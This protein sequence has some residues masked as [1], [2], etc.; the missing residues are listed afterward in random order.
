MSGTGETSRST[1]LRAVACVLLLVSCGGG[2]QG[3][4]YEPSRLS[5]RKEAFPETP[6]AVASG[7]RTYRRHCAMCHGDQGE[8]DGGS[9]PYLEPRPRDFT[10]GLFKFRSTASGELPTDEDLFRVIS[11]GA[12][13]TAMP[14]WGEGVFRLTE[15]QRWE[16]AYYV[17]SLGGEDFE[18][19]DF[20]PYREGVI[21]PYPPPPRGGP[22]LALAGRE[23]FTDEKKGGCVKCHGP[24]GRGNGPE[25]GAQRDDWGDAILPA[26]LTKSWRYKNG[27]DVRQIF[28]TLS[29]G[30]GGTPMPGYGE[31]LSEAERWS[32]AFF[33]RSLVIEPDASGRQVLVVKRAA[34]AIP[35]DPSDERWL[36]QR[37]LDVSMAGQVVYRPR[38]H[39]AAVDLVQVRAM[40][41]E[42]EI[43]FH[44]TWNDRTRDVEHLGTEGGEPPFSRHSTGVPSVAGIDDAF[45]PAK[46][47][48]ERRKGQFRDSLQ[49]QFPVTPKAGASKPFFFLGGAGGAVNLWRWFA[50]REA[51]GQER[52]FEEREQNGALKTPTVQEDGDQALRGSSAYDDGR[53]MLVLRRP[54]RTQG[55]KD[56]QFSAGSLVPFAVQA[57]D[58]GNGEEGL[59][60]SLSSWYYVRLEAPIPVS[61]YLAGVA[62]MVLASLL[63]RLFVF[64]ARRVAPEYLLEQSRPAGYAGEAA[65]AEEG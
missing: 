55:K 25:A 62:G 10:M 13:G 47:L 54:L 28:R 58:G 64:L 11:R 21:L 46:Q 8:G 38:H 42:S 20:D 32:L 6:D 9:A 37:P 35:S 30:L 51:S 57:W 52:G 60:C 22:D 27:S 56:I 7:G 43:V 45:L 44:L 1:G 40:Y 31:M 5:E 12:P 48:W 59:L 14:G 50:D 19:E 18:D 23:I 49:L 63:M 61:A 17:K 15:R 24:N 2:G 16:V 26:D 36:D 39:N 53:W 29:T 3:D 33:V 41:D 65:G 4:R 34:Q